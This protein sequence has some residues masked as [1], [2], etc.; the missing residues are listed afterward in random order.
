M[1]TEAEAEPIVRISEP[2]AAAVDRDGLTPRAFGIGLVLCGL[3]CVGLTYNRMITQGSFI[4]G[5]YYMDRGALFVLFLLVVAVNPLLGAIR[6][7]FALTRGELLAIYTMFLILLPAWVMTKPVILYT[8]GVTYHATPELR[9]IEAVPPHLLPWLVPQGAETVKDLYEGLPRGGSIPWLGWVLPLWSWGSFLIVLFIVLI[10]LGVLMR[11]QWEE[12]ERFAFP[13]MQV[14]LAMLESGKGRIAPVLRS[15]LLAAGFAIPSVVGTLRGLRYY[16]PN[17]P[18]INLGT[19]VRIFR[20]TMVLPF[21]VHFLVLAYSFFINLDVSLS[22]WVINL[23]TKVIRGTLAMVGAGQTWG[24][25]GVVGRYSSQGSE[26]L[27][28]MGM[29]Y[30]LAL[31][32]YSLYVARGHLRQ[33]WERI[34]GRASRLRDS[35]E[36]VSYRSA[37]LG[38]ALGV[39]YLGLWL[40]QAGI[41]PPLVL[42]LLVSSLIVFFVMARIVSETGFVATYSPLNPSEFVVCAVGSSAFGPTGLATLGISYVWTMTRRNTLMPHAMGAHSAGARNR[43]E[44]GAC[45]GNGSGAGPGARRHG[46]HDVALGVFPW[47]CEHRLSLVQQRERRGFAVRRVHRTPAA[48]T[49]PGLHDGFPLYGPGYR[50]CRPADSAQDASALVAV[51]SGRAAFE[52]GVVHGLVRIQRVPGVGHQGDHSAGGRGGPL[53]KDASVLH[54]DDPGRGHLLGRLVGGKCLYRSPQD[55]AVYGLLEFIV[56]RASGA[57]KKVATRIAESSSRYL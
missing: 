17:I 1:T 32:A 19:H 23:V 38:I 31:A 30:I 2:G 45:L 46:L 11:R 28:L 39:S 4:G 5:G 35:D 54:R 20:R 21:K 41:S 49:Q 42:F 34:R 25:S 6:N 53:P 14:P 44:A 29:G 55:L 48:G 33:V 43:K 8:T 22:L 3:M 9:H 47:R 13:L 18:I 36:I 7:R 51:P 10:C 24:V 52:Y 50:G 26:F 37:A 56:S 27:A 12:H 16:F 15:R 40:Y 57:G